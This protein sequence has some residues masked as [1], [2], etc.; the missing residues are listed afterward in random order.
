VCLRKERRGKDEFVLTTFNFVVISIKKT[1]DVGQKNL[2]RGLDFGAF[3]P[4]FKVEA[5]SDR[6][7]AI[8]R[9]NRSDATGKAEDKAGRT[10]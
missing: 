7:P 5:P 6:S 8:R 4:T 3:C 2:F 1:I 9:E 10:R